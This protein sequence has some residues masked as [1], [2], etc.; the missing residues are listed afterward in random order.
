M[1]ARRAGIPTAAFVAAGTEAVESSEVK[2]AAGGW[3]V[4]LSCQRLAKAGRAGEA[5]GPYEIAGDLSL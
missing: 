1:K 3:I 4:C 2:F 5:V